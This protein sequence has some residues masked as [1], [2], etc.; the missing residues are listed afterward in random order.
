[1]NRFLK[2]SPDVTIGILAADPSKSTTGGALLGDRIRMNSIQDDRVYMRS[3]ATRGSAL[4]VSRASA[5]AVDVLAAAGFDV[6]IVETS[7]IGQKDHSI[8]D[9]A[10][11]SIYV[12]TAEYGAPSQL[13]KIDMLDLADFVVVNKCRKPGSEDAVREVTLRHIRSRKITVSHSEVDS[14]LDLDLPIYATAANQFNNPG[15]NLLFADVLAGIG[16]GRRFQIDED[17]LRL[18]PTQGHKDFSRL[19]GLSTHYL[20]DIADTVENYHRK[21]QKQI[22]AAESCHALKRTLELMEGSEDGGEAVAS[23][24]KLYD[25]CKAKLDPMSAAFIEEWPAI[26]ESYNQDKVVYK[27]RGKDVEVPAKV[28]SLGGTRIP[29]VALPGYTSWGEL[30]RFFYKENRPGQFPFTA[31]V[32]PFRRVQEDPRRQFAGE[33]SP[34]KT[35][36][37]LHYLCRNDPARRLSVAFDPITLYGESPSARPDVYGKIGE[38]GVSI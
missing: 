27:A 37:R 20:D 24:E 12:M 14:I 17:I 22:E 30:L 7:G 5:Q 34:E 31:G 1:V 16:D 4:E 32:F 9:I 13:E 19:R 26:K 23:L 38:S 28:K 33:G 18:L 25:R 3:F 36:K 35:N 15:V 10:D 21:A 6:I 8:T 29:R 2:V 11:K